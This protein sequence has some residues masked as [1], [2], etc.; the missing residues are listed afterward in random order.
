MRIIASASTSH[1]ITNT[2]QAQHRKFHLHG[3]TEPPKPI[4]ILVG[5]QWRTA[6]TYYIHS[7]YCCKGESNTI[8]AHALTLTPTTSSQLHA[9]H[10]SGRS[11]GYL[12]SCDRFQPS[13]C[14]VVA[15]SGRHLSL[16]HCVVGH[17]DGRDIGTSVIGASDIG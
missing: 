2:P 17:P 16:C 4:V 3:T 8:V 5:L 10:V 9:K 13:T 14:R 6:H 11:L 15:T 7:R 12:G 1:A